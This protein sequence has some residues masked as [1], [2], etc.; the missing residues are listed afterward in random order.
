MSS[1]PAVPTC[2]AGMEWKTDMAPSTSG[3]CRTVSPATRWLRNTHALAT[4]KNLQVLLRT[5]GLLIL[6]HGNLSA[7]EGAGFREELR[8]AGAGADRAVGDIHRL[9]GHCLELAAKLP[10]HSDRDIRRVRAGSGRQGARRGSGSA[11]RGVGGEAQPAL[12]PRT[13]SNLEPSGQLHARV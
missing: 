8:L 11:L 5:G 7:P 13:Q 1:R 2:S 4:E 9:A 3:I 10:A 6:E 12:A